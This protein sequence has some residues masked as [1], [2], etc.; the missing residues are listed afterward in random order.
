MAKNKQQNGFTLIEAVVTT[1][2]VALMS[3][4]VVS[5]TNGARENFQVRNA[6]QQFASSLR[7]TIL[8]TKNGVNVSG[9]SMA[10]AGKERDCSSYTINVIQ[11]E[12]K[13]YRK[14]TNNSGLITTFNLSGGVRF[15]NLGGGSTTFEFQFPGVISG[16]TTDYIL[17]SKTNALIN[18]HVC[19]STSGNVDVKASCS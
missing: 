17:V 4:L 1:A 16:G 14:A 19:I 8:M 11:D 3:A 12:E 5:G 13:Y 7:E 9:C 6:A 18:K 15:Y 2:I 10:P